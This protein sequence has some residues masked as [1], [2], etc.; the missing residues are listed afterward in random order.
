[1]TVAWDWNRLVTWAR[2]RQRTLHPVEN[3]T[4]FLVFRDVIP[5]VQG[6]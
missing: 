6:R 1:M 5:G 4:R 2:Q 3:L